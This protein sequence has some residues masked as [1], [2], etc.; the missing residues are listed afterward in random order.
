M[1]TIKRKCPFCSQDVF[2]IQE[3]GDLYLLKCLNPNVSAAMYVEQKKD[4]KFSPVA[5]KRPKERVHMSLY[6]QSKFNKLQTPF[7]KMM[8]QK[9]KPHEIAYEKEL[10][11][12]GMTY[13]DA[14]MQ[15]S[16]AGGNQS[17]LPEWQKA[18]LQKQTYEPKYQKN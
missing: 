16:I 7:W 2:G 17:A 5:T 1:I 8:G 11:R 14:V 15:R 13:G 4:G 6:D 10:K 3:S 18:Y 12:R 9:A